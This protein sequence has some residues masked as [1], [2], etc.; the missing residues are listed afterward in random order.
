MDF[1]ESKTKPQTLNISI[2]KDNGMYSIKSIKLGAKNIKNQISSDDH[3]SMCD[4]VSTVQVVLQGE[5]FIN[6]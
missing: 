3:N 4:L 6:E 1:L 2:K 5:G